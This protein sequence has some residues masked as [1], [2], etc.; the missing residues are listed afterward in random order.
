MRS[1]VSFEEFSVEI[2][3]SSSKSWEAFLRSSWVESFLGRDSSEDSFL[4]SFRSGFPEGLSLGLADTF[5]CSFDK[6]GVVSLEE[7][8]EVFS[9]YFLRRLS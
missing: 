1:L 3:L 7:A 9:S 2:F 8:F 4:E 5:D 6:D